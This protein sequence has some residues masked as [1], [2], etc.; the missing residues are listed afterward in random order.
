[1][2]RL[3]PG[4]AAAAMAAPPTS[5][6]LLSWPSRGPPGTRMGTPATDFL[7]ALGGAADAVAVRP[8]G[9]LPSGAS[10]GPDVLRCAPLL[11]ATL[12]LVGLEV[13]WLPD[14]GGPATIMISGSAAP[15]L[16]PPLF[17]GLLGGGCLVRCLVGA[18]T[19]HSNQATTGASLVRARAAQR[20]DP[21]HSICHSQV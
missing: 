9:K 5:A 17:Q 12:P 6:L 1:V 11:L 21:I 14:G 3:P 7:P 15:P 19:A 13:R 20:P 10:M 8:A 18:T 2:R 4:A 16:L